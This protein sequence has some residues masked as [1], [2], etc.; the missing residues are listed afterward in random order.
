MTPIRRETAAGGAGR[1]ALAPTMTFARYTFIGA[2]IWGI[3]VLTPLFWLVDVTGRPYAPPMSYPHFF[4]GFLSVALAWQ[5]AFLLIGRD[6]AR[7][8]PL[9][10]VAVFEKAGFVAVVAVLYATGRLPASE[11]S[12]AAP[13]VVLG[14]LFTAAFVKTRGVGPTTRA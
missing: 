1:P 13:E 2:G 12:V 10:P 7:Y 4:Y 14:V 6:P 8:R 5:F 11:V 9:M 3:L